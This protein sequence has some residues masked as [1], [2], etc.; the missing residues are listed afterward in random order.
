MTTKHQCLFGQRPFIN[1]N[2]RFP[3]SPGAYFTF[4]SFAFHLLHETLLQKIK[5]FLKVQFQGC[6]FEVM[7]LKKEE[8]LKSYSR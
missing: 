7:T 8:I 2:I 4:V 5:V 3:L 1:M 6:R